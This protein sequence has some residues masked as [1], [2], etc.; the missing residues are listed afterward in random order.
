MIVDCPKCGY[1]S[2]CAVQNY[3]PVCKKMIEEVNKWN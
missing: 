3:C 2:R 1:Y